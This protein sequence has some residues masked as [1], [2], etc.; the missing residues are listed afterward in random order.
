[1]RKKNFKYFDLKFLNLKIV[2]NYFLK[3]FQ[4]RN[5]S[6][7]IEINIF[8]Y[9]IANSGIYFE[10]YIDGFNQY[11][12]ENNIDIE[13]KL[14]LMTRSNFTASLGNSYLMVESLLKKKNNKYDMYFYDFSFLKKY[15]PYLLDLKELLP[16]EHINMYD[17]NILSSICTYED[18]LVGIPS[19]L[20]YNALYA[21]EILLDKYNK[22]IPKTWDELIETS[23][24]ILE[25]EKLLNNTEIVGYN[26]LMYD[27]DNG[28]CSIY[29]FIYSCRETYDSP[30]PELTSN[31]TVEA[32]KLIKKI[33]EEISSDEI[34]RS[35]SVY[36]INLFDGKGLF[37]KYWVFY[38]LIKPPYVIS[39][40]PGIKEGISG[41]SLVGYNIGIYKHIEENKKEAVLKVMEF[42]TS[43]EFQKSLVLKNIIV[44]GM[45]SLYDDK[46]VCSTIQNCEFYKN[47]QPIKKPV[48]KADDYI[49]YAEKF[50]KYFYEY[51]YGNGT[52]TA[53]ST[54]KKIDDITKIYYMTIDSEET[55]SGLIIL[56]TFLVTLVIMISS[57]IFLFLKKYKLL[58]TFQPKL[59][60][61]MVI[62]GISMIFLS[63]LTYYGQIT[64]F[65]CN[66]R[67]FL[68]SFG[69]TF[70]YTPILY[71][72]ILYFPEINKYSIWVNNH[73]LVFFL[74]F[75]LFDIIL[76]GLNLIE[77]F[78]IVTIHGEKNFQICYYSNTLLTLII[79]IL[80]IAQKFIII[81]A[82]SLLIFIEWN[83]ED[84]FYDIRFIMFSIYINSFFF[85]LNFIINFLP[86]NDYI[87]YFKIQES[88]VY[89][90]TISNYFTLYG[91][92]LILPKIFKKDEINEIIK[93]VR[94]SESYLKRMEC[95]S[96]E[97][98]SFNSEDNKVRKSSI[99]S[100]SKKSSTI[101]I[102]SKVI[103][104]HYR[105]SYNN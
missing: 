60:W 80:M 88:L 87:A 53:E 37:I 3:R 78:S 16:K 101:A 70:I 89:I 83:V 105:N 104:Y 48:D 15:G 99:S 54:L 102:Y 98:N 17:D 13:V 20:S 38:D 52:E 64:K 75:I 28:L 50:T 11:A 97:T 4:Y 74:F 77:P 7:E 12:K 51:L 24:E 79:N 71:R 63:S 47:V 67:D 95:S 92:K 86:I 94:V 76:N 2:V 27:E 55:S 49:G 44:S 85:P 100:I 14:S 40:L 68:F 41:S 21:N 90:I 8:G 29:E 36:D 34:F 45:K 96:N 35:D 91:F 31:T 26:G 69:Y 57:L 23:K 65:K 5:F 62:I 1:M 61:I 25:K 39:I 19:T 9:T 66:I 56:V 30:F 82:S 81:L 84:I 73:Q 22:R 72:L 18:K 93:K 10:S 6:K 58:F 43:R 59:S 32:I 33:K 42:M 103:N 46:E